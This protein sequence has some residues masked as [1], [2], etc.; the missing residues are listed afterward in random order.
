MPVLTRGATHS[1]K[2]TMARRRQRLTERVAAR[3]AGLSGDDDRAHLIASGLWRKRLRRVGTGLQV[4]TFALVVVE[5]FL[6]IE[7]GFTRIELP[8]VVAYLFVFF[9]G[10]VMQV[11][12]GFTRH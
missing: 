9:A 6:M 5:T 12:A 4:I 2:E 8:L 7:S 10:R 3:K 11:I 1:H